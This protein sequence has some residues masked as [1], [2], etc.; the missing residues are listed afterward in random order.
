M[1]NFENSEDL[2]SYMFGNLDNKE[3]LI[4]V[5]TNKQLVI[6]VM[7]ELI[8]YKDVILDSCNIDFDEEYSSEYSVSLFDDVESD[9]WYVNVE[10]CYCHEKDIYF[11]TEGY[12]LFHEDVNSKAQI[13][14]QNNKY[15]PL[16]DYDWF[17]I[18]KDKSE[19][20]DED[21]SNEEADLDDD[22]PENESKDS[23]YSV[24]VKIGLDTDEVEEM[25]RD[26]NRNL[27]RH[28]SDMFDMLYRLYPYEYRPHPIRFFW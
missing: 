22:E 18:G 8:S 11:A 4:T 13:D 23:G 15:M 3:H 27:N 24:T 1:L 9:Y 5:I 12:V 14:M 21:D 17:T 20:T 25:I 2:V 16:R 26:M 6:D 28:V 19:D 7:K 10:K